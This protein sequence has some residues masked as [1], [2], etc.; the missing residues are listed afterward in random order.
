[1]SVQIEVAL[2][3][4]LSV[5]DLEPHMEVAHIGIE[6]RFHVVCAVHTVMRK[7][8]LIHIRFRLHLPGV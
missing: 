4:I 1:M 7:T 2:Q 8:D 5:L 3:N 6:I